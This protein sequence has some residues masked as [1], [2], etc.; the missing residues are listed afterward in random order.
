[1]I[2]NIRPSGADYLMED[3]FYAGGLPALMK[4]LGDKL[5]LTAMTVNGHTV[6]ENIAEAVNYN[7]DVIRPLTNPVYHE[8]SLAVLRGNL[9]PDGAV[10]KPAAMDTKFQTHSG[11]AIVADSY[12]EMKEI[13]NDEDYPMT[14]DH[15]LVLRNAGPQGGPGM[16]EWGMI[17]MPK[18]LLKHGHRDMV[19]LSDARM[20]GT[21]YGACILHV[22]PEAFVGGPLALIETGDIIELDV[23]NRTLNVRLTDAELAARKADWTAPEPR[24]ERGYGW[25]FSRHIEQADKGCDFDFLRT[26][27]GAPVP[28]PEIN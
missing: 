21:S 7:D 27:F 19:R 28:E 8:G 18:A 2:A 3:F 15:I 20:S 12:A 10:V 9:A 24:F 11:P 4:E 5:Y 13:I 23:P 16:P 26:E 25:M 6:G 22:A 14:P 17:P 1:M